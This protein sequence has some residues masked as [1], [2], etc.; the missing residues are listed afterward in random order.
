MKTVEQQLATLA[1]FSES[2]SQKVAA[3]TGY[4][5]LPAL[6]LQVFQ[7]N[8]GKLCNQTCRH[9]HV[10]AGPKR[11]EIMTR[12]T[13]E[14]CLRVIAAVPSFK[15]VDI[16]GGAPEMNPYFR[17]FVAEV[18]KLGRH[19]IDR[20]NLTILEEPGY[21]DL[22]EFLAAQRVEIIS[23][24]PH[25]AE[26]RTDQQRGQGVFERS[27]RALKKLNALGYGKNEDGLT[28]NLIYN[29]SGLFLS[30]PQRVLE[31]EFKEQLLSRYGIEFNHLYCINNLPINRFLDSL[32]RAEKFEQYM[33]LLVN[34]F[35]PAT[36]EGLMCRHQ[37]SVGY[38]GRIFDCDFNQMLGLESEG[39]S[40]IAQFSP[41]AYIARNIVLAN[42]CYG[43]TAG[44][45]SSCGG[46]LV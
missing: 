42:H 33:Q 45:G 34:A 20:C 18:A 21:E 6:S 41:E 11:T 3:T 37:V 13:M 10:D 14:Q 23:S 32:L 36:L 24:L 7:V 28:L 46:E 9:C 31:R 43:C 8:L 26:F 27:I 44:L 12:D 1:S 15:T 25:Y 40:H 5:R 4:Q 16:T 38:D 29:P 19:I 39:V 17:W 2:F 30:Q 22:A 35:N